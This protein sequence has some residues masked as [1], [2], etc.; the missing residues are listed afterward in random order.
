[1]SESHE[2]VDK[3]RRLRRRLCSQ[4]VD[5]ATEHWSVFSVFLPLSEWPTLI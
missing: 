1:M 3:F 4:I 5:V 2:L